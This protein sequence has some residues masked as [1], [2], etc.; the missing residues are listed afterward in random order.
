M[1]EIILNSLLIARANEH[2][3]EVDILSRI[4]VD[5]FLLT[6][7]NLKDCLKLIQMLRTEKPVLDV[8]KRKVNKK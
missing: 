6:E 8:H 5:R 4:P 7:R 3:A 2:I 1:K